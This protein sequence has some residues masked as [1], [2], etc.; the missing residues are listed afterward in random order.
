MDVFVGKSLINRNGERFNA[1]D[2]LEGKL[3]YILLFASSVCKGIEVLLNKLK[4]VYEEAFK[5]RCQFEIILIPSEKTAQ[6]FDGF[7]RRLNGNWYALP[8]EEQTKLQSHAEEIRWRFGISHVPFVLV[9]KP[10]GTFISHD[11]IEELNT[12]GIN[13]VVAWSD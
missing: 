11:A 4:E 2:V 13:V 8:F 3:V 5:H 12:L 9:V 7:F 10:D 1:L 6:D